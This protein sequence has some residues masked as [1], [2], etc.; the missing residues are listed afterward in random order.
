V[1]SYGAWLPGPR[2][3]GLPDPTPGNTVEL[4]SIHWIG[5]FN[6]RCR[7]CRELRGPCEVAQRNEAAGA[8]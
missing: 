1:D 8:A 4:W 2:F 5:G 7:D 6:P 3:D